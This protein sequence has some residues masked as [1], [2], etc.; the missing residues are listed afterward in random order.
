VK[1]ILDSID[2]LHADGIGVYF[3]SK[4]LY[5][6]KGLHEKLTGTDLYYSILKRAAQEKWKIFLLGN[7]DDVVR[8]ASQRTTLLFPGLQIV[9]FHHGYF[10]LSDS[11]ILQKINTSHADIVFI[12]LGMPKQELWLEQY[13]DTL[14][15][16]VRILS[17][18]GILHMSG[19]L[20]RAPVLVQYIGLE[21]LFRLL[22]EPK[23]LWRRYLIGNPM[24]MYRILRRRFIKTLE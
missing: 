12:S 23:R 24:F 6:N 20:W 8:N 13:Q 5:G 19:L 15:V 9:G 16:P 14:L 7:T 17:G 18:S 10:D 22:Q 2:I 3:A 4:I 11:T 21:W 1:K